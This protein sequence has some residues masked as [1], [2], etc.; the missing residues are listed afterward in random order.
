MLNWLLGKLR[1]T[2]VTVNNIWLSSDLQSLS[3][4]EI[5]VV[6]VG[7]MEFCV[8]L[9]GSN[10]FIARAIEDPESLSK[11]EAKS[12]YH[13]LESLLLD[14]QQKDKLLLSRVK[15]SYP[16]SVHENLVKELR[17]NDVS[18]R[19]L[20]ARV[21]YVFKIDNP[22]RVNKISMLLKS[23]Y[24]DIEKAVDILVKKKEA[25]GEAYT[26]EYRQY[27]KNSAGVYALTYPI[28]SISS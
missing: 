23:G 9:R 10:I 17:L 12:I 13:E 1:S 21:S 2:R 27:V 15:S 19:L 20:M 11:D 3:T 8:G 14:S 22:K 28:V 24:S 5:A 4:C 7:A 26:N 25:V 6:V 16:L 18:I